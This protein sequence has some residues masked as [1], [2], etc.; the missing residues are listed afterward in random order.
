MPRVMMLGRLPL[1][2]QYQPPPGR[3]LQA[4][5][6]LYGLRRGGLGLT[7]SEVCNDPATMF[8]QTAAGLFSGAASSGCA[9]GTGGQAADQGWCSASTGVAAANTA[10]NTA[11]AQARAAQNSGV[12]PT[13]METLQAQLEIERLRAQSSTNL[14]SSMQAGAAT[15][16]PDYT[17]YIIGGVALAA[18]L[19]VV[20]VMKKR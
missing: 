12:D 1:A 13:A 5:P 19:G 2:G 16:K 14:V 10:M 15:R 4:Q 6:G 17:P 20:L 8:M 18:L 3:L 9:T 11:C 7:T